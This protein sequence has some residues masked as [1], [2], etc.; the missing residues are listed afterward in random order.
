[1]LK[2][3]EDEMKR[4]SDAYSKW[5]EDFNIFLK[6]GVMSDSENQEQLLRLM[7]Y[8]STF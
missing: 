2:F 6:E 7:R 5:F 3:L 1:V 8:S 4:D